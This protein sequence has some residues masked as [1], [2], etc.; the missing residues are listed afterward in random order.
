MAIYTSRYSNKELLSGDYY[1]VGISLGAPKF[2]LGYEV[3][4]QCYSL[5]PKG[6][7]LHLPYDQYKTAYM[8]KL[9]AIGRDR[10]IGMVQRMEARADEECKDLVLL[11]FE[12]VRKPEDWCH[13]TMFAEWWM[14]NTGE[15]IEELADPNP[16]KAAAP[17]KA[18]KPKA[19]E[20]PAEPTDDIGEQ[21]SLFDRT[22]TR[23]W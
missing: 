19:A 8:A 5:A 15:I 6:A 7:M 20:K 18:E 1:P 14:K 9:D 17:K 2:K 23:R 12:D 13:R 16:P 10:I 22:P 11:C 21:M 4:E 3:R